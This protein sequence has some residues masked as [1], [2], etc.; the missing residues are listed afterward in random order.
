MTDAPI[1]PGVAEYLNH[2]AS[3]ASVDSDGAAIVPSAS[4]PR[5]SSLELTPMAGIATDTGTERD[6]DSP[7]ARKAGGPI[8]PA[9]ASEGCGACTWVASATPTAL[10]PPTI[11]RTPATPA[12]RA[13]RRPGVRPPGAGVPGPPGGEAYPLS[14]QD[15]TTRS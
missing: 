15:M 9:A 6:S 14:G 10:P 12:R 11:R 8:L 4:T 3:F 1:W 13:R 5:C 2:A 7:W